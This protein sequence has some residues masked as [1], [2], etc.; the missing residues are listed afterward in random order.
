M[1]S[2]ELKHFIPFFAMSS[3][4]IYIFYLYRFNEINLAKIVFM[5]LYFFHT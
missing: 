5:Y 2:G 1:G 4:N 3:L